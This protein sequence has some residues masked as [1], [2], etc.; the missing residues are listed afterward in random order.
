MKR[1]K[2]EE[3][4]RLTEEDDLDVWPTFSTFSLVDLNLSINLVVDPFRLAFVREPLLALCG[5]LG[6]KVRQWGPLKVNLLEVDGGRALKSGIRRFLPSLFVFLGI[7]GGTVVECHD[8]KR[9]G[10]K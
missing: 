2:S 10:G 9:V 6:G 7:L 4:G 8:E 3:H 5:S 1:K